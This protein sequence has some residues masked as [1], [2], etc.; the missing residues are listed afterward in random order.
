MT[1]APPTA[2]QGGK[3]RLA[4]A[5]TDLI[6]PDRTLPFYDLCCGSGAVAIEQVNRGHNPSLI[7]MVEKYGHHDSVLLYV[8]PPYLATTQDVQRLSHL[9]KLLY[10]DRI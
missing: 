1:L 2:Y 9:P 5:I 6:R 3:Q 7:H 4:A 8:D 10:F